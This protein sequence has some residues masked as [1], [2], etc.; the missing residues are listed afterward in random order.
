MVDPVWPGDTPSE[1]EMLA[2]LLYFPN[3]FLSLG[4]LIYAIVK[5]TDKQQRSMA[6]IVLIL[7]CIMPV[8]GTYE[9]LY[10]KWQRDEID[11]RPF[12]Q[13][14]HDGTMDASFKGPYAEHIYHIGGGRYGRMAFSMVADGQHFC[15][16]DTFLKPSGS[17]IWN[18]N[19]FK[20]IVFTS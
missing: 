4:C 15:M 9:I 16:V 12:N 11:R 5:L 17:A 14:K 19:E 2:A 3:F 10:P 6:T 7:S 8:W 1:H 13:K 18:H 20:F